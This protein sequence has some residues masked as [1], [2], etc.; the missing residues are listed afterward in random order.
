MF[1]SDWPVCKLAAEYDQVC[2]VISTYIDQLSTAE[3]TLIW[4]GNAKKFYNLDL[5]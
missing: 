4:S 3:Q 2:D 1:G 5:N